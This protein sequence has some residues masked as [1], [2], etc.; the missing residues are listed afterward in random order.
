MR[1]SNLSDEYESRMSTI[2]R[3]FSENAMPEMCE[4][5]AIAQNV[6]IEV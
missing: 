4:V 6:S 5:K 1:L 2:E 3:G